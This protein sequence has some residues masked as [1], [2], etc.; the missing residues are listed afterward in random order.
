MYGWGFLNNVTDNMAASLTAE[1]K[2]PFLLKKFIFYSFSSHNHQ[3]NQ[4]RKFYRRAI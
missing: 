3:R 4:Y 1:R 2:L